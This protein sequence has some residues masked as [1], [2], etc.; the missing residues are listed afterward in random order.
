MQGELGIRKSKD[1]NLA[2]GKLIWRIY[3]KSGSLWSQILQAK[4][5]NNNFKNLFTYD[6]PK[7]SCVWNFLKAYCLFLK[8]DMVWKLDRGNKIRFWRDG[9][10]ENN[11]WCDNPS[12]NPPRTHFEEF[13]G[14]RVSAYIEEATLSNF[15]NDTRL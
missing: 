2:L 14:D 4:Y 10:L 11:V 1:M 8:L 13:M 15:G 9:W 7:G 6:P 3:N 12:Y 5:L